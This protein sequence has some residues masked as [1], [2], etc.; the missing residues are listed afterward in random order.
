MR[1]VILDAARRLLLA[2]GVMPSL[3]AVAEAAGV[4]K[5]GL[6]HH[7][8]SRAA[9]IAGLAT[10]AIDDVD[11]AMSAAAASHSAAETW[12]RLSLPGVE[13]RELL[14][15]LAAAFRPSD[16][17]MQGMLDDARAAIARW[18]SLIAAEVGDPMR[19]RVIRLVGD[20]LVA[21]A[22]AGLDA[23]TDHIDEL[24][25]FLIGDGPGTDAGR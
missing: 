6:I 7:F 20:A 4:S 12:L 14:Q 9:L 10:V 3:N 15:G 2:R 5:G 13:E 17:A 1:D 19:A 22:V 25:A 23:G 16:P 24:A 21:N 11:T 18:E 8:P